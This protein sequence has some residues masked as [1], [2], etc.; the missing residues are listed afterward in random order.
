M[1]DSDEPGPI[2]LGNPDERSVRALAD[3]VITVTGSS[4]PV[5]FRPLPLDDPTRR[6]PVIERARARLG[7]APLIGIQEGLRRT[8]DWLG[9]VPERGG[10]PPEK[11]RAPSH[12]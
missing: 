4:S 10:R 8:A 5:R 2:N 3:L 12:P 11:E 6:C 1:L 9:A 7:W